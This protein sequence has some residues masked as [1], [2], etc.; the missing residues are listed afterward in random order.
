MWTLAIQIS[1]I[2]D[3]FLG[4]EAMHGI[5]RFFMALFA[6]LTFVVSVG[7]ILEMTNVYDVF[8]EILSLGNPSFWVLIGVFAYLSLLSLI[9]FFASFKKGGSEINHY[10]T[11][12]EVGQID[13]SKQS[14]ESTAM[15]SA[16]SL[17]GMRS[18]EVKSRIS[19]DSKGV[20]LII[21]YTPFGSKPVQQNAKA[22]QEKVKQDLES[23]LEVSVLEIQVYVRQNQSNQNKRQRV[24]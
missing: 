16:R 21:T 17:D 12:T 19:K 14:I 13:I 15:K 24:I 9:L 10:R 7:F 4:G 22:L 8:G 6:F 11:S 5:L 1:Q 23:W 18:L 2:D 3:K 20:K